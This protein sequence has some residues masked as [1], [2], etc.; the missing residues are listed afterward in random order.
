MRS[1]TDQVK[2]F[3]QYNQKGFIMLK[4]LPESMVSNSVFKSSLK[5]MLYYIKCNRGQMV[6]N[7]ALFALSIFEWQRF[8]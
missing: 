3:V 8:L 7:P 4:M 1:L 2:H 6:L 5:T